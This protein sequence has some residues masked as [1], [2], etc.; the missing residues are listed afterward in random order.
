MHAT[1]HTWW[2]GDKAEI[3]AT[4][5]YLESIVSSKILPLNLRKKEG[6]NS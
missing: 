6:L 1:A 3:P 2:S 4:K 5:F